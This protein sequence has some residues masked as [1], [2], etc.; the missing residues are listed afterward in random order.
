MKRHPTKYNITSDQKRFIIR[1]SIS[2][3]A[4]YRLQNLLI[5]ETVI[6]FN[7]K[8]IYISITVSRR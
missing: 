4:L 3:P 8:L 1:I 5:A 6:G 2:K 7:I